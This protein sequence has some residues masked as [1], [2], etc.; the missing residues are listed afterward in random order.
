MIEFDK[1]L[2][3]KLFTIPSISGFTSRKTKFVEDHLN[4]LGVHSY[5][6][7]KGNL[8][9]TLKGKTDYNIGLSA[10]LD[11]LGLMVRS[12]NNDGTINFTKIGGIMLPTLDGEYAT[13]YTRTDKVYTGTILSKSPSAHVYTDSQSLERNEANMYFRIDETVHSKNDVEKLGIEVGNFIAI[14]PKFVLTKSGFVKTRFLDDLASCFILLELIRYIKE[15]NITPRCNLTFIFSTYEEVGHGGSNIPSLDELLAV[16][17]GCIGKD[18][19]CTEHMVS[20][21]CK[22]SSGPYDYK[23]VNDLINL[24]K[25]ANIIYAVDVYPMYSSDA[26]AALRAGNDIR[27]ALIGAGIHASHGMERTHMDGIENTFKL[28]IEY[29]K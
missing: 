5:Y 14:D 21:C 25:Q 24:A 6:N 1:V 27:C 9:A 8:I 3:E 22:D 17:M 2:M 19:S 13:L 7:K 29:I 18:L 4:K 15:N 20:I 12:I 23:M 26:S 16:D 11:T 28:L 10:H